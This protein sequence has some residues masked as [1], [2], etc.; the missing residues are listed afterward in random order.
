MDQV[1]ASYGRKDR[2]NS[3]MT[4]LTNTLVEGRCGSRCV[5]L[6]VS[7]VCRSIALSWWVVEDRDPPPGTMGQFLTQHP[8]L[9]GQ[10]CGRSRNTGTG[11]RVCSVCPRRCQGIQLNLTRCFIVAWGGG[12]RDGW[13]IWGWARGA[14]AQVRPQGQELS[15]ELW[16]PDRGRAGPSDRQ[17][18]AVRGIEQDCPAVALPKLP[19]LHRY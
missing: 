6:G 8:A 15:S 10:R 3:V 11:V 19:L 1:N 2:T 12:Q 13:S 18:L 7:R 17:H 9:R 5:F 4:G 16:V 14:R